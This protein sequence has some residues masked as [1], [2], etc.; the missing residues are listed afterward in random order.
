MKIPIIPKI[1]SIHFGCKWLGVC[2]LLGGVIP[3][4][5]WLLFRIFLWGLCVIEGILLAGFI[6]VFIIEMQQD[7]G[8]IPYCERH[9]KKTIPFDTKTQYSV[10]QIS[11]C[12]GEKIAGFRSI[13]DGPFTE[14][15]LVRTD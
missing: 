9:L 3:F 5:I 4:I 8:K 1:N 11:T 14:V 12:A 15:M 7:F 13:N 2:F 10:I 6:I